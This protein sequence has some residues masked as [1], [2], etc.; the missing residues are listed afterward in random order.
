MFQIQRV[1]NYGTSTPAV[2]RSLYQGLDSP[3]NPLKSQGAKAF[4]SRWGHHF[5]RRI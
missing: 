1:S 5:I 4:N 2:A 3:N